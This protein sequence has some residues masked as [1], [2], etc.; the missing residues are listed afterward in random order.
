MPDVRFVGRRREIQCLEESPQVELPACWKEAGVYLITGGTGGLGLLVAREMAR[1]TRHLKLVLAGRATLSAARSEQLRVLQSL[2]AQVE[3]CSADLRDPGAIRELI[4]HVVGKF[5]ALD[6]IIHAAGVHRDSLLIHKSESDL[7]DVLSLKVTSVAALDEATAD[8]GLDCFV[9]FSSVSAVFGNAGQADYAAA[10]AFMD[11]YAEY[12]DSLVRKGERSGRSVSI[13]WPLWADGGMQVEEPLR[14]RLW[15]ASGLV[16]LQTEPGLAAL[17]RAL[18]S[19]ALQLAVLSGDAA[20]IRNWLLDAGAHRPRR[21]PSHGTATSVP[22]ELLTERTGVHLTRVLA[23]NLGMSAQS[24]DPRT[25]LEHY[26]LNSVLVMEVTHSL[27]SQFGP[28]PKALLFEHYTVEKLTAYFMQ[29]HREQL[30][31]LLGTWEASRDVSPIAVLPVRRAALDNSRSR[32]RRRPAARSVEG[33]G[34]GR[35]EGGGALDIAIVGISGRYPQARTLEEFWE[36]LRSGKDCITEI[37]AQRWDHSRY[38][39]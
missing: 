35:R 24:V 20:R 15:R 19:D 12:R 36:N 32:L 33:V 1:H 10:N 23:G 22:E 31:A 34:G 28:L 21:Q 18:R 5:G 37:P 17:G 6:G 14:E 26:G 9:L 11:G 3:Y 16:P 4:V 13:N 29:F 2:G 25:A 7:R 30:R 39:G 8:L 27:E 38:F